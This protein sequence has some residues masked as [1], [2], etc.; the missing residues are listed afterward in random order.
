M[1][2]EFTKHVVQ[3][4]QWI[5]TASV[6]NQFVSGESNRQRQRALFSLRRLASRIAT[7]QGQCDVVALWSDRRVTTKAVV[8]ERFT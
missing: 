7:I 2:I 3:Q 4:Q 5:D 8:V 1:R 6:L